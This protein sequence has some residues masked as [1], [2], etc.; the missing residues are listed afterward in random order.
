MIHPYMLIYRFCYSIL[1]HGE[2]SML[3][4]PAL[5]DGVVGL[6]GCDSIEDLVVCHPQDDRFCP[7]YEFQFKQSLN[8]LVPRLRRTGIFSRHLCMNRSLGTEGYVL[9]Y[10]KLYCQVV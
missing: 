5:P 6:T 10:L 7:T 4:V 8:F 1:D 2:C 3:I 9:L